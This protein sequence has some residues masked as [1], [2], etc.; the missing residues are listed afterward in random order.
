MSKAPSK[1]P[2]ETSVEEDVTQQD[3]MDQAK[4][5][6]GLQKRNIAVSTATSFRNMFE[7]QA[8]TRVARSRD[9]QVEE[10]AGCDIEAI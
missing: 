5:I 8:E 1:S 10:A 9:G 4:L 2:V 7:D 6:A 3:D